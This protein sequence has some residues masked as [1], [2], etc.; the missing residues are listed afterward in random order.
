MQHLDCVDAIYVNCV[1]IVELI[2]L[3]LLLVA[4]VA[5]VLSSLAV[6][7]TS[8]VLVGRD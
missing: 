4:M 8:P 5:V 6:D 7:Q 3:Q 1:V 2:L